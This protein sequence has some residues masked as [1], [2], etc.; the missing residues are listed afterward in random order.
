[1][2][3]LSSDSN[4]IIL[5]QGVKKLLRRLKLATLIGIGILALCIFIGG[6]LSDLKFSDE[7]F[8]FWFAKDW[9]I[10][11]NRPIY[12]ELVD[13][14]VE[15]NYYRYYVN[16]PLWHYGLKL[17]FDL[18]GGVSHKLAQAYMIIWYILLI[19]GTYLL[20]KTIYG[21]ETGLYSALII[22][23][24]PFIVAFSIL[25]FIDVPIATGTPYLIYFI[26]KRRY[27][28]A[29]IIMGL[30]FLLK[31][32]SYFLFPGAC[33]L[34]LINSNA[35][36]SVSLWKRFLN[37]I[38]FSVIV[39]IITIH[40]F[41]FRLDN[42]NGILVP[43]DKGAIFATIGKLLKTSYLSIHDFLKK[44]VG[45]PEVGKSE[46]GKSEVGNYLTSPLTSFP[47]FFKYF[48]ILVP[49]LSLWRIIAF[50]K[51]KD[52]NFRDVFI[53][54]PILIYIPFYFIAFQGWWEIR[55][56]SPIIPLLCVFCIPC[57]K[58]RKTWIRWIIIIIG[59]LTFLLTVAY[60]VFERNVT[61][62]EKNLLEYVKELPNGRILTP[63]ELFVSYYSGK[64]T[65]WCNSFTYSPGQGLYELF[66][67]DEK[68]E[69]ILTDFKIKYI[70]IPQ[71]RV[72][73]DR[74]E[75]H[76]GGYP[77]SFVEKVHRFPFAKKLYENGYGSLWRIIR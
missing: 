1:M 51:N 63:E 67:D 70:L 60:T 27:I 55:Y 77:K 61:S 12:N 22:A 42:F 38:L 4:V 41:K 33:F 45:K 65:I 75:K 24:M 16:A 2:I 3:N 31:E 18:T 50:F 64:P 74:K 11:C 15:H 35:N 48:G 30:M 20:T 69:G 53:I 52:L 17:I 7:I 36:Y 37:V 21:E 19:F 32:N 13:T 8:H 40:N 29:G 28:T 66:W 47:T 54:I 23:T 57:L 58:R 73:D 71:K 9:H 5:D 26:F 39:L 46:V 43:H 44:E 14:V 72:Y 59:I 49:L 56:L 25:L 68:R 76:F 62:E 6:T 10:K 34:L